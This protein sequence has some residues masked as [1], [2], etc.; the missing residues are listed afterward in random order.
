MRKALVVFAVLMVMAL[1]FT[2]CDKAGDTVAIFTA[3]GGYTLTCYKNGTWVCHVNDSQNGMEANL[4]MAKG[5]YTGNPAED[6]PC[7]VTKTHEIDGLTFMGVLLMN[8]PRITNE[9]V[10][11]VALDTPETETINITNG[12][13]VYDNDTYTRR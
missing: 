1:V 4:D 12:S 8:T 9:E 3:E 7:T 6:G 5:T 11:L 10:P 13:F 2:G